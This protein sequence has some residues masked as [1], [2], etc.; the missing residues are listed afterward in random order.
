[1]LEDRLHLT[2]LAGRLEDGAKVTV[3]TIFP[4]FPEKVF[5]Q[6]YS[7]T[8]RIPQGELLKYVHMGYGSTYERDLL[9]DVQ[10][11]VV[12]ARTVR[13]NEVEASDEADR[14]PF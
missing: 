6:W 10:W 9:L 7:G 1:M 4:G 5:A 14:I 11:G 8:L 2:N 3:A 12:T 13:F